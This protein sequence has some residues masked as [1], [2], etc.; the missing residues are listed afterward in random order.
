MQ[1]LLDE[2]YRPVKGGDLQNQKH[3]DGEGRAG[4]IPGGRESV[5]DIE[6]RGQ[7]SSDTTT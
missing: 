7:V 2:D 1:R 4:A 5:H 6:V 3:R